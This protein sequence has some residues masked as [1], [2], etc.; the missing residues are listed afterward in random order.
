MNTIGT[1][2]SNRKNMPKALSAIKLKRLRVLSKSNQ[3]FLVAKWKDINLCGRKH[4]KIEMIEKQ[5]ISIF[6]S[7]DSCLF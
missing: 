3:A 6:S 2:R 1:V 5:K 7:S 4:N